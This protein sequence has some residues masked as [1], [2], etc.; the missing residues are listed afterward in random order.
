MKKLLSIL[1]GVGC[2]LGGSTVAQ[3]Q[4]FHLR[5]EP[6][7]TFALSDPQS[8]TY[9][10]GIS[11]AVKPEWD[12]KPWLGVG[13]LVQSTYLPRYDNANAG[14]VWDFGGF[15]RVKRPHNL[16]DDGDGS[17]LLSPWLDGSLS[18]MRTGD[19]NRP[20]VSLGAGLEVGTFHK[21][22][23]LGPFVRYDHTFNWSEGNLD[24]REVNMLTAGVSFDFDF[25]GKETVYRNVVH[26]V[27]E[28]KVVQQPPVVITKYVPA[29]NCPHFEMSEIVQF[30]YDSAVLDKKA[31]ATLD[32]VVA[33]LPDL[34]KAVGKGHVLKIEGHA[35]SEGEVN[36][37]RALSTRRAL[38]VLNYLVA[39]GV[40]RNRLAAGGFGV[41]VPVASNKTEKGREKNRRAEFVVSF[42]SVVQE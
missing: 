37:N 26:T 42:T 6:G 12:V 15:V 40:P 4:D 31:Q 10:T 38:A 9:D 35:S 14:V 22:L 34:D 8:A 21:V 2:V 36:Y 25:H 33:K 3:A 11:L 5:L 16:V 32:E 20:A 39:H 18:Y 7:A 29:E 19:V 1:A 13:P 27:R 28:T 30:P 24:T 41:D 17:S 23:W